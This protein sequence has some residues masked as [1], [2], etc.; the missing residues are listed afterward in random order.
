M[1]WP[2]GGNPASPP[3]DL[4]RAG[5]AATRARGSQLPQVEALLGDIRRRF[6]ECRQ[7]R[8]LARLDEAQMALRQR[9]VLGARQTAEDRQAE[10]RHGPAQRLGMRLAADAVEDHAGNGD[11]GAMAGEAAQQR[12]DR[13]GL[14]A[15][16]DDQHHRPA[17]HGRQIG[18]R[19]GAVGGAVEQS[20]DAFAEDELGI[21]AE[22]VEQMRRSSPAASPRGR[23]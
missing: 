15:H 9:Q 10:R 4:G 19:A 17:G 8:A 22:A 18:G 23:G 12:R 13:R 16:I 1:R 7:V 11:V 14:A 21:A 20:H 5:R 3:S 6:E 2:S